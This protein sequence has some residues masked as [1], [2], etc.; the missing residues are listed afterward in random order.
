MKQLVDSQ[1][2]WSEFDRWLLRKDGF[3]KG[4]KILFG[5][6]A[7]N[8]FLGQCPNEDS[9]QSKKYDKLDDLILASV[10]I[11]CSMNN[12]G[13]VNDSSV[14]V[15]DKKKSMKSS[16]RSWLIQGRFTFDNLPVQREIY[17]NF[18]NDAKE[19]LFQLVRAS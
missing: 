12:L 15:D 9:D 7:S 16:L 11:D 14:S 8:F 17:D 13:D 3:E 10:A 6:S 2:Q 18:S 5:L 4:R 19:L 1:Q